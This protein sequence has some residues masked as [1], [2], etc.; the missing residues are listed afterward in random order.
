MFKLKS[1]PPISLHLSLT[2][3]RFMWRWGL[4]PPP[5]FQW[6]LAPYVSQCNRPPLG[7]TSFIYKHTHMHMQMHMHIH[8]RVACM[9]SAGV[10]TLGKHTNSMHIQKKK[11]QRMQTKGPEPRQCNVLCI[12]LFPRTGKDICFYCFYFACFPRWISQQ[13]CRAWMKN[14]PFHTGLLIQMA[15]KVLAVD[16][17]D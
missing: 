13:S 11:T 12:V 5:S 6:P 17:E 14:T 3:L 10:A 1:Q 4:L 15:G 16:L 9:C 8:T 7:L 2:S